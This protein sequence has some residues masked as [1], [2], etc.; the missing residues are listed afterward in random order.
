MQERN[1]FQEKNLRLSATANKL[2]ALR[3]L[4][5]QLLLQVLLRPGEF[6][7]SASELIL[8]CKK[9]F[10]SSDLLESSGDDEIDG[11]E[12]PELMD[13]LVDTLLSLLPQSSA[14]VRSA[15]EQVS[16]KMESRPPYSHLLTICDFDLWYRWLL[17]VSCTFI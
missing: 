1:S 4:L 12:T 13:V 10:S 9:A 7:E 15:I 16:V 17:L 8:C 5:I 11:D 2:H 14:P 3:Y 6:S